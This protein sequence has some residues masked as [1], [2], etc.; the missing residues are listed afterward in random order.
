MKT[1]WTRDL[2]T[3]EGWYWSKYRSKNGIATVPAQVTK[4][5][6]AI[7]V[8]SAR[9]SIWAKRGDQP[10]LSLEGTLDKSLWF[11]PRIDKPI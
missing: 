8:H 2:P 5:G 7:M 6:D 10:L 9:G 3:S 1:K 11:G 4:I